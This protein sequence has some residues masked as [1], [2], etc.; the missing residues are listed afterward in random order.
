VSRIEILD[1]DYLPCGIVPCATC[2]PNHKT[3]LKK[4]WRLRNGF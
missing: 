1:Q 3:P 2:V 4:L